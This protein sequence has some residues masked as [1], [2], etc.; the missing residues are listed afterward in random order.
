[1][2]LLK[3]TSRLSWALTLLVVQH[4]V[5]SVREYCSVSSE[6]R[7]PEQ[8]PVLGML[9]TH[10]PTRRL[11]EKMLHAMKYAAGLFGKTLPSSEYRMAFQELENKLNAFSKFEHVDLKLKIDLNR[12]PSLEEVLPRTDLLES[13]DRLWATEGLGHLYAGFYFA[14]DKSMELLLSLEKASRLSSSKMVPLHAGIGLAMSEVF[15]AT[16]QAGQGKAVTI[17]NF[18]ES[19]QKALPPEYW[20]IAYEALGLVAHNLYP[21]FIAEIEQILTGI[22]PSLV[23]YFWH[24]AGRAIYFSPASFLL[25]QIA[26]WHTYEICL[27]EP[28]SDSGRCNAVAGFAWA[29][30]L[31]NIRHPQILT[32][33]LRH[34]GNRLVK[35]DAFYN[36]VWAALIIWLNWT[37][38][39]SYFNAMMQ[40]RPDASLGGLWDELVVQACKDALDYHH[41]PGRQVP[42]GKLFRYFPGEPDSDRRISRSTQ[43][44]GTKIVLPHETSA[45]RAL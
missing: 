17:L 36:G 35:K 4:L 9:S 41:K 5:N 45:R 34:H 37:G 38:D 42:P 13:Y 28:A 3:S 23:D 19:C 15:L 31:V 22:D 27:Q 43:E 40:F 12:E 33:F 30:T 21:H 18:V 10:L 26:P 1:M 8:E 7:Q 29:L 14:Q 6:A 24:G 39:D 11:G 32:A 20:G 16:A 44:T 25:G 2:E